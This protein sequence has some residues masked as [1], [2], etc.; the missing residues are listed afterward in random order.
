M[1]KVLPM[2]VP[3]AVR[4]NRS[5][6]NVMWFMES[7]LSIVRMH[8]DHEP[9]RCA[10]ARGTYTAQRAVYHH[11]LRQFERFGDSVKDRCVAVKK[12]ASTPRQNLKGVVGVGIDI[13]A[14]FDMDI[15]DRCIHVVGQPGM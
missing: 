2:C 6:E 5:N 15:A 3:A 10:A 11:L 14:I 7:P 13:D 4:E 1:P 8:R 9:A 12:S